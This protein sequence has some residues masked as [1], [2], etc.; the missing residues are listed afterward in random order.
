MTDR[1]RHR[2]VIYDGAIGDLLRTPTE[3]EY[4]DEAA[5]IQRDR[6]K[7]IKLL[8]AHDKLLREHYGE[9]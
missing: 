9:A 1:T 4:E 7:I 2:R 8:K 5:E 6:S 3:A